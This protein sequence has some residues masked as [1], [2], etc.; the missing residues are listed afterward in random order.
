MSD[1]KDVT[2]SLSMSVEKYINPHNDP[3]NVRRW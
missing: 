1:R 2:A 3:R